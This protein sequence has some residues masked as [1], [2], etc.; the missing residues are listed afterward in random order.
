MKHC[1]TL[2]LLLAAS[3][4]YSQNLPPLIQSLQ[5]TPDWNNQQLAISY[6]VADAEN[7]PLEIT[8][9]FSADDGKTYDLGSQVSASGDLGYPVQPGLKHIQCDISALVGLSAPIRVRLIADDKQQLDIPALLQQVDSNR[10]KSNLQFVQGVRHR[11]TGATHLE[12]TRDSI[13]HC[14]KNAGLYS[15]EQAVPLGAYNG[16]NIIGTQPGTS[17]PKEVII[18]DAHYDSVDIAPGADDN[19]SGTVGVWEAIYIL[20]KYPAKK[21]IRYIAFDLEESGLLGSKRYVNYGIP[22]GDQIKAV[23]NYEMIGFYSNQPNTQTLPTGFPQLFPAASAAVAADQYRGNFISNVGNNSSQSLEQTFSNAAQLYVPELKVITL[24]VPGNGAIAPDLRRSD[25]AP[26]WDKDYQALQLTDGANFRNANYH[27]T[28]D[29]VG[30]LNFTFMS[31]VVKA[32]IAAMA[33]MA[34]VQHGDWASE[35]FQNKVGVSADPEACSFYAMQ[36]SGDAQTLELHIK[37]CRWDASDLTV[38]DMSGRPLLHQ[39]LQLNGDDMYK[40]PLP[41][42]APGMYIVELTY[43][44]GKISQKVLLR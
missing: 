36:A 5:L 31:Q 29:T 22:T 7:D 9:Q 2:L 3:S 13:R 35:V 11:L 6:T 19:G 33:Q 4:L 41:A 1:T 39:K 10:L 8:L 43:P 30:S 28:T 23:F 17:A 27:M 24:D 37:P 42:P 14:F 40:L 21:S 18:N 25:H 12:E 32:T 20:S 26:F 15:E 44:G 38:Y 34:E 16:K